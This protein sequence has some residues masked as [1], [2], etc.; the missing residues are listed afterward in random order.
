MNSWLDLT[1]F[2]LGVGALTVIVLAA[3][4]CVL[5]AIVF[6]VMKFTPRLHVGRPHNDGELCFYDD[7]SGAR[8]M[9]NAPLGIK[10]WFGASYRNSPR[11]FVG[12]IRWEPKQDT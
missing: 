1:I 2:Y 7:R 9:I 11:W 3:L 5:L 6:L 10:W 8:R 4:A 12:L